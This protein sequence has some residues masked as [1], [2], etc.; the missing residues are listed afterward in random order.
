MPG[1]ASPRCGRCRVALAD[2]VGI[3][4]GCLGLLVAVVLLLSAP[5]GAQVTLATSVDKL[6]RVTAADGELETLLLDADR[7]RPG[8]ELRYTIEFTN[9]SAEFI[10]PG[11]VVITNPI[12]EAAE[13]LAGSA[14]GADTEVLFSVDSGNSF[15]RPEELTVIEDGVRLLALPGHYTTVRWIYG[16]ILGPGEGGSVFFDVRLR[17]ETREDDS[18]SNGGN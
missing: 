17:D 4:W 16:G 11:I 15:A 9:T 5:A 12:P 10:D 18:T 2:S 13:Y 7:V 6:V 14:G 1:T 8:E 3:R